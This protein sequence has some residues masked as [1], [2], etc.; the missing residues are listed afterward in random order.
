MINETEYICCFCE[1]EMA[2]EQIFCCRTYKGKMT[3]EDFNE[4]YG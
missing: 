3:L 4:Y 2:E 1:K